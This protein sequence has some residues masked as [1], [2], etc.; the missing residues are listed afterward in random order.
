MKTNQEIAK[1]IFQ[2][3]WGTGAERKRRLLEAGYDYEKIQSIV[4][5][6]SA[7]MPMSE[8]LE[9]ARKY[10]EYYGLNDDTNNELEIT[11]ND[12]LDLEIDLTKYKGIKLTFTFGDSN[13]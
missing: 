1:E 8:I 10:D 9:I 3:K 12:V 7:S 4:N 2:G 6:I 5:A 13:V 11:G